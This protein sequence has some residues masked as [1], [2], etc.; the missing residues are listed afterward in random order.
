MSLS[1]L[2]SGFNIK[3][4]NGFVSSLCGNF[5]QKSGFDVADFVLWSTINQ[6]GRSSMRAT[7]SWTKR[8]DML[9][10][11]LTLPSNGNQGG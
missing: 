8:T 1:L 9:T 4:V 11:V 10:C 2:F 6:Q 3:R 5:V 7:V